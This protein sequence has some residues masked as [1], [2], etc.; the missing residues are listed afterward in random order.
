MFNFVELDVKTKRVAYLVAIFDWDLVQ[1][2][3][4]A[5]RAVRRNQLLSL[6]YIHRML[7]GDGRYEGCKLVAFLNRY[8]NN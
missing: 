7:R 2:Q 6:C 1:P 3:D 4:C 5:T 8:W